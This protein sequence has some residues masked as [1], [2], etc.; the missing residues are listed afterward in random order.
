M[1]PSLVYGF[2]LTLLAPRLPDMAIAQTDN[3]RNIPPYSLSAPNPGRGV[4]NSER[5]LRNGGAGR[6]ADSGYGAWARICGTGAPAPT[7]S[8]PL[9]FTRISRRIRRRRCA[10]GVRVLAAKSAG[11]RVLGDPN[12][13]YRNGLDGRYYCGELV[14]RRW[15]AQINRYRHRLS[16]T[17]RDAGKSPILTRR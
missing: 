10:A 15:G 6:P 4:R 5:H 1:A 3:R 2:P 17:P 16:D 13:G 8:A 9:P 12:A 11:A 14:S 7:Q